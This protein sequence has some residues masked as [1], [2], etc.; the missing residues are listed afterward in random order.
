MRRT[1]PGHTGA[2]SIGPHPHPHADSRPD[3]GLGLSLLGPAALAADAGPI[4]S[5]PDRPGVVALLGPHGTLV[6]IAA[7][8][9]VRGFLSR[10][11]GG[12]GG[13]QDLGPAVASA[14]WTACGSGFEAD[15]LYLELARTLTP[16]TYHQSA[17]RWRAWFLR[18]DADDRAPSWKKGDLREFVFA[19]A[20]DDGG[21][22][23][24]PA[25]GT[26]RVRPGTL[27]GP[28]ATKHAAARFGEGLDEAFDLCR[29]PRRLERA[30]RA[31]A[32]VYKEMGR[33]P[34]PCDGSEPMA[35]FRSRVWAAVG[36]V[37]GGLADEA[38]RVEDAMRQAASA[39][40]FERAAALKA[41]A[42]AML[43]LS[44][45]PARHVRTL[46]RFGVLAVLPAGRAGW[47]R[48]I[49]HGGGRTAWVGDAKATD[50]AAALAMVELGLQRARAWA[51]GVAEAGLDLAGAERAGMVC[52]HLFSGRRTAGTLLTIEPRPD[53]AMVWRA[54]GRA[55][56]LEADEGDGSAAGVESAG[57]AIERI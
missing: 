33:C 50:R 13:R 25:A 2:G 53:P 30:P 52:A 20:G 12:S 34:A 38:A 39:M 9:S 28:L 36:A 31:E 1:A 18:L 17:D 5:A 22:R 19:P 47:F 46:E 54:V 15:C 41:R 11:C 48:V 24:D 23:G 40:A 14:R 16:G 56:R 55:S 44:V 8:G 43:R 45:G 4:A 49:A 35:S 21:H 3:P 57:A 7:T 27:L 42:E 37:A 26:E 51:A 10:R 29:E 32:C 6:L